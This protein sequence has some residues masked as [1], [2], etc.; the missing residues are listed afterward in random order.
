MIDKGN[1]LKSLLGGKSEGKK[2]LQPPVAAPETKVEEKT[3][4]LNGNKSLKHQTFL[5]DI[6]E[7]NQF[8]RKVMEY[9]IKTSSK[10]I[11]HSEIVR[12]FIS[13]ANKN[14]IEETIK[15]IQL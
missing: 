1:R 6:D 4:S 13:Y 11:S 8:R 15:K 14:G 3:E 10:K 9:N 12:M 7:F 2:E 5:L